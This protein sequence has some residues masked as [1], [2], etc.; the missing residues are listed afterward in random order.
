MYQSEKADVQ[1]RAFLWFGSYFNSGS[2]RTK[3]RGVQSPGL[4]LCSCG[5]SCL[6]RL[7]P[8]GCCRAGSIS[9]SL[10]PCWRVLGRNLSMASDD[11]HALAALAGLV[12]LLSATASASTWHRAGPS[13]LIAGRDYLGVV[14]PVACGFERVYMVAHPSTPPVHRHL[15]K[16]HPSPACMRWDVVRRALVAG[17]ALDRHS[18]MSTVFACAPLK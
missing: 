6:W 8:C 5:V 12:I 3:G 4:L 11:S 18:Q 17:R 7:S 10:Y 14:R 16:R 13:T 2:V 15:M 1:H 9:A